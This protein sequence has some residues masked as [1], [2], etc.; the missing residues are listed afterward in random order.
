MSSLKKRSGGIPP[1]TYTWERKNGPNDPFH[2][3]GTG[4]SYTTNVTESF[5]LRVKIADYTKAYVYTSDF[6]VTSN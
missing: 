2:Q 1:Y 6:S 3:V 5:S 4:S